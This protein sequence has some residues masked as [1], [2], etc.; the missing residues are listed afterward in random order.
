MKRV[1]FMG[2]DAASKLVPDENSAMI[3]ISDARGWGGA[4]LE[5]DR[6][7]HFMR[8]YFVDGTFS[9]ATIEE[10]GPRFATQFDAYF[11]KAKA[12]EIHAFM[13][14]CEDMS[15]ETVYV[16]CDAGR[17]RSAA[18]AQ[19]IHDVY[20]HKLEGDTSQANELV[21]LLLKSP[22]AFD[23]AIQEASHDSTAT[24]PGASAGSLLSRI[25]RLFKPG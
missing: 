2:K 20:G 23:N 8:S 3:S 1:V 12:L 13:A 11:G 16:H 21:L 15:I 14:N 7:R 24:A 9:R 6:F 5:P 10:F 17:S 25:K 19:W 4:S 22:G 18:V